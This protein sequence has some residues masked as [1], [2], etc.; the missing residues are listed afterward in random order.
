MAVIIWGA[1]SIGRGFVAELFMEGGYKI[2]FVDRDAALVEKL[3]KNGCYT[4]FKADESGIE[5]K[6]I[7]GGFEAHLPDDARVKELFFEEDLIVD[8]AVYKQDLESVADMLTPLIVSRANA[9]PESKLD[10]ITNVNMTSPEKEMRSMLEAR[11]PIGPARKYLDENTGVSGI[12]MMCISPKPNAEMLEKDPLAVYNNAFFE[13]AID[14]TALKGKHPIAPRL[15]LSDR[16]EAEEARKLYTLNMAHCLL[17]YLG[18][19]KGLKTS[20]EAVRDEELLGILKGALDESSTGLIKKFG[21]TP[22]EM[23][24]WK[25]IILSLLRNPYMA[26][27]L[28]RLGADTKRKLGAKDRLVMPIK[29]C[30]EA[31]KEPVNLIKALNAGYRFNND[32]DGTRQVRLLVDTLGVEKAMLTVSGDIYK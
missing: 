20:L 8:V 29:L 22:E 32:D 19:P 13:Q 24:E 12:F 11:L 14:I 9:M 3:N 7:N 16:L 30:R 6:V 23:D 28:S 25:E 31:G 10:I 26:D 18:T 2:D 15:R 4:I 17:A 5:P 21:F 27:P 1:G